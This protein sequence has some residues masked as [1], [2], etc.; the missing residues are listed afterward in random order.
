MNQPHTS[1]RG[2]VLFLAVALLG[3]LSCTPAPELT[4]PNPE[5][6]GEARAVRIPGNVP[7]VRG[8]NLAGASERLRAAG[9]DPQVVEGASADSRDWIVVAQEPDQESILFAGETVGLR[10]CPA[11]ATKQCPARSI[12]ESM[13]GR[14]DGTPPVCTELSVSRIVTGFFDA[15]SDGDYRTIETLVA[16]PSAFRWLSAGPEGNA[17][18]RTG[19]SSQD[20]SSVAAYA[21]ARKGA[22][23]EVALVSIRYVN[24]ERDRNLAH[25]E[26]QVRRKAPDLPEPYE[27]GPG[28]GALDCAS[29]AL[30]VLSY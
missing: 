15:F 16:A 28:K 9:F 6:S 3:T 23:E 26:I 11:D 20:R 27:V 22:G 19:T 12:L 13:V 8:M 7:E 5:P 30:A 25:F 18:S 14:L 21:Q 17:G 29:G 1:S 10:V 24:Y 2:R 4:A